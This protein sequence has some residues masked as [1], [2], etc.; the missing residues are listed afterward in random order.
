MIILI[1]VSIVF[2]NLCFIVHNKNSGFAF[3]LLLCACWFLFWGN[4]N[5]PDYAAYVY[6]YDNSIYLES[7]LGSGFEPGFSLFMKIAKS[8]GLEYEYFLAFYSLVGFILIG[9]SV[10]RYSKKANLILLIYSLCQL[11]IDATQVRNFMSFAILLFSLRFIFDGKPLKYIFCIV[12]GGLFHIEIL[13]YLPLVMLCIGKEAGTIEP[14]RI[15]RRYLYAFWT[16]L[17]FALLISL[18]GSVVDSLGGLVLS[19]IGISKAEAYLATR[20]RYGFLVYY[21]YEIII[22][23]IMWKRPG[24]S[25]DQITRNTIV[26]KMDIIMA[27]IL[28]LFVFNNNFLRVYRNLFLV[29]CMVLYSESDIRK[30]NSRNIVNLLY[31]IYSSYWFLPTNVFVMFFENQIFL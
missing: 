22:V 26:Y 17:F 16:I 21:L 23:L 24:G 27:Y 8:L 12:I 31:L 19:I 10:W 30:V 1:F 4:N 13:A 29:N 7:I 14:R 18:S 11:A 3:I 5:N 6:K 2:L 28:P 9:G 25:K 20:A 15:K